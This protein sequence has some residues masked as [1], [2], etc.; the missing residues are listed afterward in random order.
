MMKSKKIIALGLTICML[1][2]SFVIF[3]LSSNA[4]SRYYN[5]SLDKTGKTTANVVLRSGASTKYKK[6]KT[7]PKGKTVPVYGYMEVPGLNWYKV[8]YGGTTGY[9]RRDYVK[10]YSTKSSSK[11]YNYSPDKTGKTTATV[12]LRSGASTKYKKLKTIPKGKTVPVYG[13]ME[14]PGLN[15]Y[16]VRY[17][18]TTGY[19]RR[20]YVKTYSVQSKMSI[21]GLKCPTSITEG[22]S[23]SISGTVK[24]N[25]NIKEIKVGIMKISTG[26]F[27]SSYTGSA[28]PNSTSYNISRLDSEIPFGKAKPGT[29][30]FTIWAKDTKGKSFYVVKKKFT[31]NKKSIGG[32]STSCYHN[33]SPD[34]KGKTTASVYMRK[35][36]GTSYGTITTVPKGKSLTI[37]GY[38]E[39][40]GINWYKVGYGGKTGYIRR[41][42]IKVID[43]SN[44]SDIAGFPTSYQTALKELQ[45]VYPNWKFVPEY[46]DMSWDTLV[47]NEMR[48]TFTQVVSKNSPSSWK[49]K[50]SGAV[51]KN[52][53]YVVYDGGWNAASKEIVQYYLDPRNFLNE[54]EIYQFM[55]HGFDSSF[56]NKS[57]IVAAAKNSFMATSSYYSVLYNSGKA[58]GVNPNVLVSMIIM[59]QGWKGGTKLISGKGW[60]S[61]KADAYDGYY[62][63]FNIGAY[64]SGSWTASQRG[65]W[66][67]KGEGKGN[68][69]WNR[70]WN[71]KTKS[72]TGGAMFYKSKYMENNQDTFYSKKFNVNNGANCAGT[73][74]YCTNV[75]AASSEGKL[76]KRGFE[77]NTDLPLVFKI[78]V[79]TDMPDSNCAKPN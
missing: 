21:S 47:K 53:N 56:Q 61:S 64:A 74:E 46:T 59:E 68:T 45:A 44:M 32:S 51:D 23:Y 71:S 8:R 49:S 17:G 14:V 2:T 31:V 18:G 6:L 40:P 73:H 69:T 25:Y 34:K 66:Y 10:T 38:M 76:L 43:T 3:P 27:Y 37:Y 54:D 26:K 9:V 11:Y 50:A 65:L 22:K 15:W 48:G 5:Y 42:Y 39:V 78:P 57:T 55:T 28:K 63:F 4:K 70:P 13:Y 1:A 75:Q 58:S 67:A 19:V 62:N 60:D 36:A 72:I 29:Y 30:Y 16:K 12:V 77:N 20:D 33:Y 35:G 41:D 7:I 79:Y 24:S 52:G